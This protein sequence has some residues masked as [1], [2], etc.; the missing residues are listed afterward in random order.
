VIEVQLVSKVHR[1]TLDH[2]VTKAIGDQLVSKVL[3]G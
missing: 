2:R 1:V 3:K